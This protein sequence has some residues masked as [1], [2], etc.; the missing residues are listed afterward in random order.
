[1]EACGMASHGTF[2]KGGCSST[3]PDGTPLEERPKLRQDNRYQMFSN[4]QAN[5]SYHCR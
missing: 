2:E 3:R 5:D 4:W 1:L